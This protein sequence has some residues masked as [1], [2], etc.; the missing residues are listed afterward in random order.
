M[1]LLGK[2]DIKKISKDLYTRILPIHPKGDDS[3]GKY[4]S[5]KGL[6]IKLKGLDLNS[7]KRARIIEGFISAIRFKDTNEK[8]KFIKLLKYQENISKIDRS[9]KNFLTEVFD[10]GPIEFTRHAGF[11]NT[12]L[13]KFIKSKIKKAMR[14]TNI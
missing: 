14:N 10:R 1:F 13:N 6:E 5:L 3:T 2:T 12:F 7:T 9:N 4:F 8:N 11:R